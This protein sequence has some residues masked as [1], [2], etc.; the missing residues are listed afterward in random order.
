MATP[1]TSMTAGVSLW[2]RGRRDGG[3][4]HGVGCRHTTTAFGRP[5]RAAAAEEAATPG[6]GEGDGGCERTRSVV[7]PSS[8]TAIVPA[9]H[10]TKN[11]KTDHRYFHPLP[12]PH[13][14]NGG[15]TNGQ[16]SAV[17]M[18]AKHT[19]VGEGEGWERGL[20]PRRG[21]EGGEGLG[22]EGGDGALRTKEPTE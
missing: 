8:R 6:V 18:C 3:N 22:L 14:Q 13:S 16:K 21:G 12:Q 17:D 15:I 5:G 1:S 19:V 2:G 11:G 7:V 10:R 9:H 4:A 20:G